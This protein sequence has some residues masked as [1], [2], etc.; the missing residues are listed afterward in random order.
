MNPYI[1]W[2]V[3]I[4]NIWGSRAA[5]YID[6]YVNPDRS[7]F[8]PGVDLNPG[9]EFNMGNWTADYNMTFDNDISSPVEFDRKIPG[10]TVTL[11][12]DREMDIFLFKPTDEDVCYIKD[13]A[14]FEDDVNQVPITRKQDDGNNTKENSIPE[15]IN[16]SLPEKCRSLPVK[17][18]DEFYRNNSIRPN[19]P[20]IIKSLRRFPGHKRFCTFES[21]TVRTQTCY[22][23]SCGNA[24]I[25][26]K[27]MVCLRALQINSRLNCKKEITNYHSDKEYFVLEK[28][29]NDQIMTS[30]Q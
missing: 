16:L 23:W 8:K 7:G 28:D 11:T 12:E 18:L 4:L 2:F 29:F 27:T 9:T 5:P 10:Q 21:Q 22:C 30:S 26:N 14:D 3:C 17:W 25:E 6:P 1:F 20:D 24:S 15:Q 19:N 13:L